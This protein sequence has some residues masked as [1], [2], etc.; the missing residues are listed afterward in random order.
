MTVNTKKPK[1]LMKLR[2]TPTAKYGTVEVISPPG[3]IP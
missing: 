2:S 1:Q 3:P